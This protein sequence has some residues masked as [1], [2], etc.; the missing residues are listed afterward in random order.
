[1]SI[2]DQA[3]GALWT[4]HDDFVK[5]VDQ[6]F[7]EREASFERRFAAFEIRITE[8]IAADEKHNESIS[9]KLVGLRLWQARTLGVITAFGFITATASLVGIPALKAVIAQTVRAEMRAEMR[10]EGAK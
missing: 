8:H 6:R 7:D 5:A 4:K 3:L 2:P 9:S 10:V 1:M